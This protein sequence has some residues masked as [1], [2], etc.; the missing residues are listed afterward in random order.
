MAGRK[1]NR[2]SSHHKAMFRAATSSPGTARSLRL[3]QAKEL[4]R[5]VGPSS[6]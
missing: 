3:Y 2:N 1:L 6:P 5:Y 4:R